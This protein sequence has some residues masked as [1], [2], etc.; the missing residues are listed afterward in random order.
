MDGQ[1]GETWWAD[2]P[3]YLYI[4]RCYKI[5]GEFRDSFKISYSLSEFWHQITLEVL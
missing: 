3:F 4:S 5:P 2:F 1:R